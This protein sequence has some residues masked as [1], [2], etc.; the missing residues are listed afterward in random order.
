MNSPVDD[1]LSFAKPAADSMPAYVELLHDRAA[2]TEEP[3]WNPED[4]VF[5]SKDEWNRDVIRCVSNRD[6]L[7]KPGYNL[8]WRKGAIMAKMPDVL[9]LCYGQQTDLFSSWFSGSIFLATQSVRIC[10]D[11]WEHA[12]VFCVKTD[13]YARSV[14]RHRRHILRLVGSD[15]YGEPMIDPYRVVLGHSGDTLDY[16]SAVPDWDRSC[17]SH[18]C[19]SE[20]I[21]YLEGFFRGRYWQCQGCSLPSL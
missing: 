6:M 21:A 13:M 20:F 15:S 5:I 9:D 8:A 1:F 4:L 16:T 11:E 17:I 19:A 14:E 12:Y 7:A 2:F 10:K 3:S 18:N